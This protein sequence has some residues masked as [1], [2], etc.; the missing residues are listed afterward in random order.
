MR[1]RVAVLLLVGLLAKP[2]AA[3]AADAARWEVAGGYAFMHDEDISENFRQGWVASVTRNATNWLGLVGEVGGNYKTLSILGEPPRLKV[4]S[5]MGGPKFTAGVSSRIG[6]F[7]QVLL[8]A[9]R[10]SSSVLDVGDSTTGFAYQPGGGIDMHLAPHVGA[11]VEAD[12][13]IIRSQGSNSKESRVVAVAVLGLG[14]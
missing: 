4:Y 2:L 9:A 12:Y 10:A 7:A 11:R 6:L 8:G 1:V 13:R 14:R 5:F 3:Q